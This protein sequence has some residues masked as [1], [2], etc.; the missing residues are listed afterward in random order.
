MRKLIFM[1]IVL[2]IITICLVFLVPW[3]ITKSFSALEV[4]LGSRSVSASRDV[5]I[6]GKY[7]INIFTPDA[8]EGKI[9]ISGYPVTDLNTHVFIERDGYPLMY[10]LDNGISYSFGSFSAMRFLRCS[11]IS[12]YDHPDSSRPDRASFDE[13]T[14]TVL[15]LNFNTLENA[16]SVWDGRK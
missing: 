13:R 12:I 10:K 2:T 5:N 1:C 11:Y 7:Y 3:H 15:F 9:A 6:T 16:F 4:N 8:F 14:G